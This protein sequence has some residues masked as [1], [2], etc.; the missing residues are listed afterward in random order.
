MRYLSYFG[1]FIGLVLFTVLI[2]WQGI[3]DIA[4]IIL[5]SGWMLLILPIVWLPNMLA[6]V[7]SWRLLFL[8]THAPSFLQ[9]L[10]AIWIGRAINTLLPVASLGGEVIKARLLTLWGTSGTDATAS[11]LV[12]KTVQ[13]LAVAVWAFI[14]TLL[15][16]YLAFDDE[17]A[18][19]AMGGVFVLLACIT[20]FIMVQK[21]GL[22]GFLTRMLGKFVASEGWTDITNNAGEVDAIVLQLYRRGKVLMQSIFWRTLCLALQTTEVWFACYLLGQPITVIEALMLKSLTSTLSDIAF[23]IPNAYGIQE[24][25]FIVL[26]SLLGFTPDFSLAVSLATR[27]RELL[28]DVPGLLAWQHIEARLL[29]GN[30]LKSG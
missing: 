4:L 24:G 16:V 5:E 8:K 11:V 27:I 14:G 17:L 28:V 25:G 29:L 22:A 19:A 1:L 12:D 21:A 6:A 9:A 3:T 13:A 2:V 10:K 15:L 23:F 30:G 18:F 20:G 7:V 26:G